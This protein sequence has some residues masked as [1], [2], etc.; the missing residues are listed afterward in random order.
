MDLMDNGTF[1]LNVREPAVFA[2]NSPNVQLSGDSLLES[3]PLPGDTLLLED[4]AKHLG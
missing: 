3:E 4:T 1:P 2:G